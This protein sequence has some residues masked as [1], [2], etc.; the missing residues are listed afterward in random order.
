MQNLCCMAV[1]GLSNTPQ[2]KGDT[3]IV[4][5]C[6]PGLQDRPGQAT[7]IMQSCWPYQPLQDLGVV[8]KVLHGDKGRLPSLHGQ[9]PESCMLRG[10]KVAALV[11]AKKDGPESTGKNLS[12]IC[13][14]WDESSRRL[15]FSKL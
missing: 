4:E 11:A 9:S 10:A 5:G 1:S 2:A 13:A 8:K 15:P 12:R 6:R 7:S 3:L 14:S